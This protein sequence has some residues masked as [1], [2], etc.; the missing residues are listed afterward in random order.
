MTEKPKP[1]PDLKTDTQI[2]EFVK[3]EDVLDYI[4]FNNLVEMNIALEKVHNPETIK[5]EGI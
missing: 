3:N 1:M 2:H 5:K 4:D